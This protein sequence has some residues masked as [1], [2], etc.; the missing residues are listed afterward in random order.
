MKHLTTL[1]DRCEELQSLLRITKHVINA[2]LSVS[3]VIVIC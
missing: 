1:K 2:T 3:N